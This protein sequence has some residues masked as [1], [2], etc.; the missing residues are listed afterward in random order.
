[1]WPQNITIRNYHNHRIAAHETLFAAILSLE[2]I[3]SYVYILFIIPRTSAML[4]KHVGLG[5]F[6]YDLSSMKRKL[7]TMRSGGDNNGET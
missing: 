6:I 1:M 7:N 5:L 3:K 4:C 2:L